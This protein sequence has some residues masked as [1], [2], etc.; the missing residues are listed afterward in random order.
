MLG[1][2]DKPPWTTNHLTEG[3]GNRGT[4]YDL[5]TPKPEQYLEN[6]R[7]TPEPERPYHQRHE[8]LPC[9]GQR[10]YP[11]PRS[12]A[13]SNLRR[14]WADRIPR[15][16]HFTPKCLA[17]GGPTIPIVARCHHTARKVHSKSTNLGTVFTRILS[18]LT[19]LTQQHNQTIPH[20][21]TSP[22]Q[23]ETQFSQTAPQENQE[24]MNPGQQQHF[25]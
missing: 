12:Q 21:W 23:E 18:S 13:K 20:S 25:N 22:Q 5:R 9:P 6:H 24:H 4:L 19:K 8:D 2:H 1:G 15:S 10:W 14:S 7:T 3:C 11:G 16:A 17:T